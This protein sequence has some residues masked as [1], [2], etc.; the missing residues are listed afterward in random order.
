M[1]GREIVPYG[2][3]EAIL[4]SIILPREVDPIPS[5]LSYFSQ[6]IHHLVIAPLLPRLFLQDKP[7]QLEVPKIMVPKEIVRFINSGSLMDRLPNK[8]SV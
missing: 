2:V 7:R 1:A 6:A 8:G 5:N 3:E 4:L